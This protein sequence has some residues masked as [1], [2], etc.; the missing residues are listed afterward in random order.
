MRRRAAMNLYSN[1][2]YDMH[3]LEDESAAI[4]SPSLLIGYFF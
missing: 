1:I 4:Y 3:P 2:R